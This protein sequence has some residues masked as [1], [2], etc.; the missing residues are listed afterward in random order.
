MHIPDVAELF[1][2]VD[3]GEQVHIVY[4]PLLIA[5]IGDE[6]LLEA[7]AD[8][9]DRAELPMSELEALAGAGGLEVD[10]QRVREVIANREG[11]PRSVAAAGGAGG[12][13]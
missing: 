4:Q 10:W 3:V 13:E 7:H 5:S 12:V 1:G 2:S 11:I 6:I 8:V 9:Y